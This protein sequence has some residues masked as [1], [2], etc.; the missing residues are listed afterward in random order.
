M[1]ILYFI[2][3]I[4]N[5]YLPHNPC[6]SNS[7]QSLFSESPSSTVMSFF[8]D[9]QLSLIRIAHRNPGSIQAVRPLK[10]TSLPSPAAVN[11]ICIIRKDGKPPNPLHDK[12]LTHPVS[13]WSSQPLSSGR[14]TVVC[15]EESSPLLHPFLL[16]T[17]FLPLLPPCSASPRGG[18]KHI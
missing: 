9:D 8:F 4:Y 17:F 2:Y 7:C 14:N 16:W 15:Q 5:P 13:S 11:C 12:M 10:K 1:G 6:L 18:D 3:I